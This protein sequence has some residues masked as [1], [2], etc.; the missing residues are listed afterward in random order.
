[1]V[2]PCL[3]FRCD[4]LINCYSQ[5]FESLMFV[6]N[7]NTAFLRYF[8]NIWRSYLMLIAHEENDFVNLRKELF[9]YLIFTLH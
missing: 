5:S 2:L 6:I 8:D 4:L 7:I 9:K 3:M 1:M